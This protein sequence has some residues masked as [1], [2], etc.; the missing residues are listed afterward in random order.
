MPNQL[1]P[2]AD[3][4]LD[5]PVLGLALAASLVSGVGSGLVPAL[6]TSAAAGAGS[7]RSAAR[8][9]GDRRG[10]RV[11]RGLVLFEIATAT[12]LLASSA[13]L[14][15]AFQELSSADPGFTT[16]RIL[17]LR[18][19]LP[20]AAYADDRSLAAAADELR[21]R[22][23]ALPGVEWSQ[24]WGPGRPGLSFAFQTSVPD[25]LLIDEMSKAP[26]AR[27]HAV[28]PGA[29]KDMGLSLVHGRT[30]AETDDANA[31]HVAVIGESMARELWPGEDPIGKRYHNF[32]P[33]GT[34]IPADRHWTVVGV[35]T[36]AKH[37]GRVQVAGTIATRNDSYFSFSQRPE[38]S[39]TMLVKTAAAPDLGPIRAAIQSFD[40]SIPVF[41]VATMAENFAQEERTSRFSAQLMAGFGLAALLL[42]ALGVYGVLS[43]TVA[44]RRG[45]IG[46]R[47]AL[48]ASAC[49]TLV[50]VVR[51]GLE[52]AVAGVA[53]GAVTAYAATRG[54]QSVVPSVPD[55]DGRAIAVAAGALVLAAT[56]SCLVP[57][58]RAIR[59]APV[60]AL[61]GE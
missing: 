27:R 61:K 23:E 52:L 40:R 55:M 25:E 11:R 29:L 26:L 15:R 38:R 58:L 9:V 19:S 1:P 2:T 8:T 24:P 50:R 28:G 13:L 36:D 4:R 16:Q 39:F 34:A 41:Q 60:V 47:T 57:A 31:P 32:Q 33:P 17:T 45:E 14:I 5:L 49:S 54:V 21:Q 53:L 44:Q 59:I 46:L 51:A 10:D 42:T 48:G 3:V 6:R 22:I 7:L 18:L 12:I 20:L 35:V 37:G 56:L 30:I 43:F